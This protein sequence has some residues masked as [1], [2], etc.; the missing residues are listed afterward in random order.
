MADDSQKEE[1][2][3]FMAQSTSYRRTS[4]IV[5]CTI[6]AGRIEG[7]PMLDGLWL[8][9]LRT[10]RVPVIHFIELS[11]SQALVQQTCSLLE[12]RFR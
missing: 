3:P 12:W 2:P 9:V 4:D 1:N 8:W 7:I 11:L 10:Q 5:T 6:R